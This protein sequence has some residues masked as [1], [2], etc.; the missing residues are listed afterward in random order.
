MS[1]KFLMRTSFSF[2]ISVY[3]FFNEKEKDIEPLLEYQV[4]SMLGKFSSALSI[5]YP[6]VEAPSL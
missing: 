4:S 2:R 1:S 3:F 6:I 5:C